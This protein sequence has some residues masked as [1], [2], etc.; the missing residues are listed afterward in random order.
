MTPAPEPGSSFGADQPAGDGRQATAADGASSSVVTRFRRAW[1]S[2]QGGEDAGPELLPTRLTRACLA[3]LPAADG[4]GLSL[5]DNDFRVPI[6]ATDDVA[7][8]AE[9][10]QFT[11]GEGPCLDAA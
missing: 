9:R 4:A 5:L 3:V 8:L 11:I 2:Q 1:G 6:G 10:L 7:A